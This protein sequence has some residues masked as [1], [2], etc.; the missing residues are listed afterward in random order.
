MKFFVLALATL[1]L[2]GCGTD[3]YLVRLD[4]D[5]GLRQE[6]SKDLPVLADGSDK[7][8]LEWTAAMLTLYEKCA[9]K[10]KAIVE[11]IDKYNTNVIDASR[12]KE[13]K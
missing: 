6:C 2:T 7:A 8:A 4:L 13:T 5:E 12:V 10:Q 11:A 1:V 3:K 9:N